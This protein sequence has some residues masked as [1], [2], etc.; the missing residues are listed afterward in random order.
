LRRERLPGC[1]PVLRLANG[2]PSLSDNGNPLL[3][4]A[5]NGVASPTDAATRIAAIPGVIAH[6]F[7]LDMRPTI[8][9]ADANDVRR[10]E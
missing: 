8:Y 5:W 1:E 6:G 4:V 7:F 10:S 3:D 2:E 9:V